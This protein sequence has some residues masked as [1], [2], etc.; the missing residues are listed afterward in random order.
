MGFL[1]C[2]EVED[3]MPIRNSSPHFSDNIDAAMLETRPLEEL[4]VRLDTKE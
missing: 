3:N 1:G 4:D 2:M